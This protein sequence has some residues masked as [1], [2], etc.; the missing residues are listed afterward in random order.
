MIWQQVAVAIGLVALVALLVRGKHAPAAIFAGVAFGFILLG[1]IP[2]QDALRQMTNP[3]VITVAVV[4][5]LSVVLDK[6]RLLES[7]A[8]A[9]VAGS[10][11]GALVRLLGTTALYSAFIN[12]TAV[13][14]SL[15]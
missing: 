14:A 13:V 8:E 5:L 12:N 3:G 1:L 2:M 11:R 15:Y 7:M 6:S 10:Y 4:L 9:L